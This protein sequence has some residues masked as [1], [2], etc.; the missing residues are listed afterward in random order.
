MVNERKT[1]AAPSFDV[2]WHAFKEWL[3]HHPGLELAGPVVPYRRA[4][5]WTIEVVYR[6]RVSERLL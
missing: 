1:F 2:V 3:L 5:G 4:D 6:A